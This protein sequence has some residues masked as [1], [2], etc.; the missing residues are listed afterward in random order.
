[1]PKCPFYQDLNISD[2]NF[3]QCKKQKAGTGHLKHK[4]AWLV[5]N[6][7]W[8]ARD[9]KLIVVQ[10]SSYQPSLLVD[11]EHILDL[12]GVTLKLQVASAAGKN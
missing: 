5:L 8:T 4:Q 11:C 6:K 1:M 10:S 7:I 12:E 2:P 3:F 9:V